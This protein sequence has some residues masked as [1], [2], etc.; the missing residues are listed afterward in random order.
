MGTHDSPVYIW[1]DPLE[2]FGVV[3]GFHVLEECVD[4]FAAWVRGWHC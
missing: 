2:Y 4:L 1:R 3:A